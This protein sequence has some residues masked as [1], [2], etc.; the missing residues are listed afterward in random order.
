MIRRG[1]RNRA[2]RNHGSVATDSHGSTPATSFGL[3][4]PA[5]TGLRSE[6]AI[7]DAAFETDAQRASC[8]RW[9]LRGL[10]L[11]KAIRK[12]ETDAEIAANAIDAQRKRQATLD[13]E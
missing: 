11:D 9:V 1:G 8:L 7:V 13:V 10:P 6:C 4:T 5:S 2:N 12:V 3:Q